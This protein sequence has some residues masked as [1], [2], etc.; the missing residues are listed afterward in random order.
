MIVFYVLDEYSAKTGKE[1]DML[2]SERG[3]AQVAQP[4]AF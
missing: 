3:H 4:G 2:C 1:K